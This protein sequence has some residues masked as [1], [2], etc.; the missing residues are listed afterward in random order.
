MLFTNTDDCKI[1]KLDC[2]RIINSQGKQRWFQFALLKK[3]V[4][5]SIRVM[6]HPGRES[7]NLHMYLKQFMFSLSLVVVNMTVTQMICTYCWKREFFEERV[8]KEFVPI[9]NSLG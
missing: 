7:Q 4:E 2:K 1:L 6:F 8:I 3:N 9:L 5:H